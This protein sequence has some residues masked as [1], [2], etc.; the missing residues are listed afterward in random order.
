MLFFVSAIENGTKVL[1]TQPVNLNYG[2]TRARKTMN[3]HLFK[4][5]AD[6]Q[7]ETKLT[8]MERFIYN[9]PGHKAAEPLHKMHQQ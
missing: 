1:T 3:T 6:K 5:H 7:Y 4:T 9:S 8:F 2:T